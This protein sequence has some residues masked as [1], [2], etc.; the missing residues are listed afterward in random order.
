MNGKALLSFASFSALGLSRFGPATPKSFPCRN[1]ADP[2]RQVLCSHI[3]PKKRGGGG[4]PFPHQPRFCHSTPPA[5]LFLSIACAQFPSPRVG[6]PGPFITQS[7]HPRFALIGIQKRGRHHSLLTAHCLFR[8]AQ[9]MQ[10]N[11]ELLALLVEMTAFEAQRA[12]HVGHVKV[13]T[14]NFRQQNFFLERFGA[15]RQRP[16]PGD[17]A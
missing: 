13:L 4:L 3:F 15:F 7:N 2:L 6:Y 14:P 9:R 1:F 8:L 10:V 12:R 5:T 11:A 17:C 16:A